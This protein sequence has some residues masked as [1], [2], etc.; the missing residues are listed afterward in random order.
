MIFPIDVIVKGWLDGH[1]KLS[2]LL[3]SKSPSFVGW[4]GLTSNIPRI[5]GFK[6][7]GVKKKLVWRCPQLGVPPHGWFFL[8]KISYKNGWLRVPQWL[9]PASHLH[10]H[11][12]S[13][14]QSEVLQKAAESVPRS[15]C[16]CL[17]DRCKHSCNMG[18]SI[19]GDPKM[20]GAFHW[21]RCF[22]GTSASKGPKRPAGE[23]GEF[24][25]TP[26]KWKNRGIDG[27]S[28]EKV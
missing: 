21:L 18:G 28:M 4:K 7:S 1:P 6:V 14:S 3:L 10:Q 17:V 24:S 12:V 2:W 15:F 27:K 22:C 23:L 26:N 25:S 9:K 8:W 13:K 19:N 16:G 5:C 11:A 20:L